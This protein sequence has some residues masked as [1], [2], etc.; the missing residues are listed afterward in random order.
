M[1][2]VEKGFNV[3]FNV[4]IVFKL[5][6]D[7]IEVSPKVAGVDDGGVVGRHAAV[8]L[9]HGPGAGVDHG[10]PRLVEPVAELGVALVHVIGVGVAA[11]QLHVVNVPALKRLRILLEIK[12]STLTACLLAFVIPSQA[13]LYSRVLHIYYTCRQEE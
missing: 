9:V 6:L 3:H 11:V 13:D 4:T 2:F 12:I 8:G 10:P 7:I 1:I 5:Y